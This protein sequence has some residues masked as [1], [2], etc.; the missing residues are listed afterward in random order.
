MS[1]ISTENQYCCFSEEEKYSVLEKLMLEGKTIYLYGNGG[2][3]KSY[4]LSQILKKYPK[5]DYKFFEYDNCSVKTIG[6]YIMMSNTSPNNL[7]ENVNCIV[8]FKG[9]WNNETKQYE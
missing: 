1:H 3:G 7:S 8:E 2:N 5:N 4:I 9:V 6:P